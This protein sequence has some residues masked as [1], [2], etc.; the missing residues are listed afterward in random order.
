M[1][2]MT[3]REAGPAPR[4]RGVRL[5]WLLLATLKED[6]PVKQPPF[7]AITFALGSLWA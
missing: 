1:V 4:R 5:L 2:A 6:D 7:D 3:K